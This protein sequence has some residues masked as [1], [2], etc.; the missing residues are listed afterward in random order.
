MKKMILL[1]V[2]PLTALMATDFT[3]TKEGLFPETTSQSP[4]PDTNPSPGTDTGVSNPY[5]EPVNLPEC[6]PDNPEVQFIETNADW[7]TI[8]SSNKRIFCVS[9]GDYTSLKN[10]KITASGTAKKRR[11]IILNNKNNIHPGKLNDSDLAFYALELNN[12]DYWVIDRAA[13]KNPNI[14]KIYMFV[15]GSSFNILN[16][17]YIRNFNTAVL[18]GDGSNNNTIQQCRLE[19]QAHNSR[20]K[21]VMALLMMDWPQYTARVDIFNTKIIDNEIKNCNDGLHL[22]R[23]PLGSKHDRQEG[24]Y[25]GTIID[26]N[27]MYITSDIYTD[28][29]GNYTP[30]GNYAYAENAI[31]IKIGSDNPSNPMI[32]TNNHFW[33][34]RK[35]DHTDSYLSD[36][37][38]AAIFHFGVANVK[39]NDN[40]IFDSGGGFGAGDK[41]DQPFGMW[42]SE[43]KRNLIVNSGSHTGDAVS[44]FTVTQG[45]NLD[46]QDNMFFDG[47]STIAEFRYCVSKSDG[48]FFG[49]NDIIN[50]QNKSYW[51]ENN[52]PKIQGLDTNN[53]FDTAADGGYTEDYIFTTDKLT[54]KPRTIRLKNVLKG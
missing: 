46:I 39:F 38:A 37:G 28:G 23:N 41:R 9:P 33:G 27:D 16:R 54:N 35:S 44:Q 21:D 11:Y 30:D 22:A 8:N 52:Y 25:E 7:K 53:I 47:R 31:D 6:D 18:V 3:M 49:N 1:L 43:I 36:D 26:G 24:N 5:L 48:M 42:D 17:A 14:A 51:L 32:I 50:V 12:A 15:Y 10:I 13:F 20:R 40:I 19:N 45:A 34:Y 29:K 2:L 4:A